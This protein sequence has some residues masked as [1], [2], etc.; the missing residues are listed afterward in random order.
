M[1]DYNFNNVQY[2]LT[3]W[4]R[5]THICVGNLSIIG[6]DNGMSPYRRQAIIWTNAGIL[7]IGPF[8]TNFSEISIEILIF[9]F[10]K[11]SLRNGG[12]F[13]RPQWVKISPCALFV[14][15]VV[16]C[17]L[18]FLRRFLN[19]CWGQGISSVVFRHLSPAMVFT[20]LSSNI[21]ISAS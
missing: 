14:C 8:G 19:W 3:H 1:A 16:V 15:F 9:S 10:A 5:A 17:Y 11:M 4:G 2:I 12:H 7:L 20:Q 13:S 21:S 6:S 18:P